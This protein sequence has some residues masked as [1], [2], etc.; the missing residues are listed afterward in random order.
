[1]RAAFALVVDVAP[2]LTDAPVA[3]VQTPAQPARDE[4]RLENWDV[5]FKKGC[6]QTGAEKNNKIKE[7]KGKR[8]KRETHFAR[9]GCVVAEFSTFAAATFGREAGRRVFAPLQVFGSRVLVPLDVVGGR[10][11]SA[12]AGGRGAGAV[13][14]V[15]A[16]V[17]LAAAVASRP[18]L[19]APLVLTQLEDQLAGVVWN[20][21]VV[22]LQDDAFQLQR[23]FPFLLQIPRLI[24]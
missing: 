17:A 8:L 9:T 13:S 15:S 3:R 19:V 22:V 4:R 10:R 24:R 7:K 11:G 21:G 18:L 12:A 5:E 23:P 14:V 6:K 16:V 20:D 1:M 2:I